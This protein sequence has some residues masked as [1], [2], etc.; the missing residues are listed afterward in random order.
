MNRTAISGLDRT[1]PSAPIIDNNVPP[2]PS[3]KNW[4]RSIQPLESLKQTGITPEKISIPRTDGVDSKPLSPRPVHAASTAT[5]LKKA[6]QQ[7]FQYT[8]GYRG[9]ALPEVDAAVKGDTSR[10]PHTAAPS[11]SDSDNQSPAQRRQKVR[12]R[13]RASVFVD[14][15]AAPKS[16]SQPRN[17]QHLL[18]G[19]E[20]KTADTASR[21]QTLSKATSMEN[22]QVEG[23]GQCVKKSLPA[24]STTEAHPLVQADVRNRALPPIV[25]PPPFSTP[26]P[27]KDIEEEE[28]G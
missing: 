11:E 3:E 9:F 10:Q 17:I 19:D 1:T 20:H 24:P 14:F 23:Q 22:S 28:T 8:G 6:T 27:T 15:D 21:L 13:L 18:R 16:A 12:E 2:N 7:D 4:S 25:A 26:H 5:F